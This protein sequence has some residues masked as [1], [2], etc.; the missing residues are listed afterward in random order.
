MAIQMACTCGKSFSVPEAYAG[1]KGSCKACGAVLHIPTAVA[2]TPS[3]QAAPPP[4]PSSGEATLYE[5]SPSMFRNRPLLF[6]AGLLL[7]VW[8]IYQGS[9][10]GGDPALVG[11]GIALIPV[12][13]LV[14]LVWWL[15]CRATRLTVTERKITLRRGLLGRDLN[16]VRHV[17]VR[18]VRLRQGLF[19][20][21]LGVGGIAISTSGQS[22]IEVEVTG[23]PNPHRIREIID[24]HRG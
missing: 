3:N 10:I 7:P 12:L 14:Y 9:R 23:L 19:Q 13:A 8:L 5:A 24:R 2:A 16:E 1:K 6:L 15:S 22:D 11:A 20:R 4:K 18:N 21:L 17:D